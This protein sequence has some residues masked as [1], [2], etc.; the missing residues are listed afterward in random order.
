MNLAKKTEK[1]KRARS[2][3]KKAEQFQRIID[4]ARKLF[5]QKGW[6]GFGMRALA[7]ELKMSEGNLYNYVK[8]KRELWIAIRTQY[9]QLFNEGVSKIIN[10]NRGKIPYIDILT[11]IGEFFLNFSAENYS[12]FQI[13][14]EITAPSAREVGPIERNYKPFNTMKIIE[15]VLEEAIEA[16]EINP[17]EPVS[18]LTYYMYGII[19]GAAKM[20]R[21]LKKKDPITE[22]IITRSKHLSIK[23][24]REFIIQEIRKQLEN[25][26]W[27]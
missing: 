21:E 6:E 22:L 24:Y 20:E 15:N 9:Y 25:S 4:T 14:N 13:M 10:K 23:E 5:I 3:E 27:K 1:Q 26:S 2:Q 19:Y 17:V 11:K 12:R 16:G 7:R 18:K 8:S